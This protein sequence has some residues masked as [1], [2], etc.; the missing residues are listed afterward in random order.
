MQVNTHQW[1]REAINPFTIKLLQKNVKKSEDSVWLKGKWCPNLCQ[2]AITFWMSQDVHI[3]NV[4]VCRVCLFFKNDTLFTTT[5]ELWGLDGVQSIIFCN[6]NLPSNILNQFMEP[7]T[8]KK[9]RGKDV[10]LLMWEQRDF[11]TLDLNWFC[12]LIL[13]WAVQHRTKQHTFINII[14]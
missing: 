2:L 5:S 12:V 1:Y 9:D 10:V 4:M 7:K 8:V 11:K 13:H 6:A 3:I 14:K